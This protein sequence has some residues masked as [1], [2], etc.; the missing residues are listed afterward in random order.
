[1]GDEVSLSPGLLVLPVALL[2]AI[3][4][5]FLN[6][7]IHRLPRGL[8]IR[9]PRWSY[10][11]HCKHGVRP[12]DNVPVASW[13]RL[14]GRCR[15]CGAPISII[16]PVVELLSALAFVLV[17]DALFIGRVLAGIGDVA[18][19]WPIALA[20]LALFAGLLACS[21]MDIEEYLIDVRVTN[22][23]FLAGVVLHALAGSL[24]AGVAVGDLGPIATMAGILLLVGWWVSPWRDRGGDSEAV[25]ES[26]GAE[27]ALSTP[28]GLSAAQAMPTTV[29]PGSPVWIVLLT[30]LVIGI[31]GFAASG[32]WADRWTLSASQQRAL[33]GLFV[34]LVVLILS[35]MHHRTS[36]VVMEATIQ[37]EQP[38]ARRVALREAVQMLPAIALA[39]AALGWVAYTNRSAWAWS[40]VPDVLGP[41]A[42]GALIGG[43]TALACGALAAAIGWFVRIFFTLLFGKEAYG[44]GDIHIM[45]AIGAVAGI[46]L[47]LISFFLGAVLALVGVVACAVRKSNRTLPFGPWLAL[48][49]LA[50]LWIHDPVVRHVE[51][52]IEGLRLLWS[53]G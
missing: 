52:S 47:V 12:I 42:D 19:D 37:R 15:D 9:A 22:A 24:D 16:Y 8:S 34:F 6:V 20:Y 17:W 53:G 2:G 23:V 32:S 25:D 4:G 21:A 43:A 5:S 10:C 26:A 36:D 50:G 18:T 13:L 38:R 7:V 51:R 45:A 44:V 29:A 46:G 3:V 27:A 41:R 49:A 48:G 35:G 33:A 40:D 1:M 14:G 28:H 31:G 39:A 30:L 11:P